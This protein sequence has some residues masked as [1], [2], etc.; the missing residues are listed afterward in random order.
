M[1]IYF[2]L[3]SVWLFV[4]NQRQNGWNDGAHFFVRPR[5]T[6]GKIYRWSIFQ[7]LAS[8]KIWLLKILK[9]HEF[10]F[11]EPAKLFLLLFYYL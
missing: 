6:T 11:T 3:V 9:I 7:K 5:V 1:Y 4:S 8:N 2:A 10:F